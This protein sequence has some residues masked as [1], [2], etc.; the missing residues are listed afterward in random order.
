MSVAL[1]AKPP[2]ARHAETCVRLLNA[3]NRRIKVQT[4]T[5]SPTAPAHHL[6]PLRFCCVDFENIEY[7]RAR[8]IYFARIL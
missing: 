4:L 7:G 1:P 6:R 5:R 2:A 3:G 8:W